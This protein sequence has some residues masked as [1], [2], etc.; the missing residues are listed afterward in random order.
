ML[1]AGVW[2]RGRTQLF[3]IPET[4]GLG[5]QFEFTL[6]QAQEGV[7][8]RPKVILFN[9]LTD[10]TV[11]NRTVRINYK[12]GR[13]Q[14]YAIVG[15]PT[16]V[17]A[18]TFCSAGFYEGTPFHLLAGVSFVE[19]LPLDVRMKPGD[20]INS[21]IVALQA[22][23]QVSSVMFMLEEWVYEAPGQVVP[24]IGDGS[25]RA[26]WTKLNGTLDKLNKVLE[27]LQGSVATP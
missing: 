12:M 27:A 9:L 23:D 15:S 1:T 21:N 8:W 3:N 6:P 25:D 7:F 2:H 13:D 11:A 20:V 16:N 22:G 24:A 17:P 5:K 26:D 14:I 18:T 10:A 19:A 4:P